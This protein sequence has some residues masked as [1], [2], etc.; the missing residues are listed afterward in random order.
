MKSIVFILHVITLSTISKSFAQNSK[1]SELEKILIKQY[2]QLKSSKYSHSD[3]L[4]FY[5]DLFSKTFENTIK[6]NPNT[7]NYEFRNLVNERNCTII[8]SKDMNFRVYSWNLLTGGTMHFYKILYQYRANNQIFSIIPE[9]DEMDPGEFC[10]EIF[11][12]KIRNRTYYLLVTNGIYTSQDASQSV[13]AFTIKNKKMIDSVKLFKSKKDTL[14][15]IIV[16]FNFLSVV[17]R[18]ERPLKLITYDEERKILSIPVVDKDGRV[19]KKS[20]LYQLRGDY[21]EFLKIEKSK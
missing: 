20:S 10:S 13:S 19:I 21:F 16:T 9:Y 15:E 6:N 18:P 2:S 4:E 8:T 7:L 5:S 3:S 11:T 17:D 12:V 1:I 14:H